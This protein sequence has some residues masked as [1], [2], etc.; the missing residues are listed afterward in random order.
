MPLALSVS[1]P[2]ELGDHLPAIEQLK[3]RLF[4][5]ERCCVESVGWVHGFVVRLQAQSLEG[6]KA[7]LAAEGCTIDRITEQHYEW[8]ESGRE[9]QH[10][11]RHSEPWNQP[12]TDVETVIEPVPEPQNQPDPLVP[13][14]PEPE[15]VILQFPVAA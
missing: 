9:A 10:H 12:Q 2:G 4:L 6:V 8:P 11:M 13:A 15:P 14:A 5:Q 3:D 7:L 1:C